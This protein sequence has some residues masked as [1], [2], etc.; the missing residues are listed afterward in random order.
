MVRRSWDAAW[1]LRDLISTL[2]RKLVG[3]AFAQKTGALP[4]DIVV[5]VRRGRDA[6]RSAT[7]ALDDG[8]V[9][10]GVLVAERV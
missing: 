4:D 10:Y 5:D 1:A 9:S 3:A 7:R 8:S 2:K 6:I